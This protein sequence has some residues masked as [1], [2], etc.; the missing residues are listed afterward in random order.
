ME[1]YFY[2]K[3]WLTDCDYSDLSIFSQSDWSEPVTSKKTIHDIFG[4]DNI[5]S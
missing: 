5:Y 3:E 4:N 1:Y 2:L